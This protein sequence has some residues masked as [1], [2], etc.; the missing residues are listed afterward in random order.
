MKEGVFL[1]DVNNNIKVEGYNLSKIKNKYIRKIVNIFIFIKLLITNFRKY[2]YSVCYAPGYIPSSIVALIAS[3]NNVAWMHTNLHIYMENYLPYKNKNITTDKKVKK[4]VNRM[5]FRKYKKNIFVSYNALSAYLDV[6]PQ[7]KNKCDVIYNIID[8][9]TIEKKSKEKI[10]LDKNK[11]Y[12]FI[13]VGRHTEFDKRLSRIINASKKLNEDGLEFKVL[14]VG[15]GVNTPEYKEM[16]KKYKLSDRVIFL[17]NKKNPYPYFLLGDSFILSSEFEGLPTTVMESL[18]L[19]IPIISTDVSDVKKLI[20]N[21]YGIV[22][23][24]DDDSIYKAMKKFILDNYKT[25]NKF[26]VIEFNKENIN[27]VEGILDNE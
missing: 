18:V 16:V 21:K 14:L 23:D 2:D 22:G 10:K 8:N 17:G 26:N 27:K 6:F 4:F 15:E 25:N 5:F 24:K 9:E 3:K 1:K 19:N 11:E 20:D 13:S 12:T 7:D